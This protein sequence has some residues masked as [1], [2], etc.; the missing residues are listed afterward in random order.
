MLQRCQATLHQ[1]V[2]RQNHAR[3]HGHND[4]F[5]FPISNPTGADASSGAQPSR[6]PEFN[7]HE[8]LRAPIPCAFEVCTHTFRGTGITA[9]LENGGT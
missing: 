4:N 7:S 2:S 5:P 9:Y 8:F 3:P 1:N 6:A